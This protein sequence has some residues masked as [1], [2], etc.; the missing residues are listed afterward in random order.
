MAGG[1]SDGG[2]SGEFGLGGWGAGNLGADGGS[3]G[4][5]GPD[6]GVLDGGDFPWLIDRFQNFARKSC[7]RWCCWCWRYQT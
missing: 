7:S 5:A 1:F 2:C 4:G 3:F 6:V